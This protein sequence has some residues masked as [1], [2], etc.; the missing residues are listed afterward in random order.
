VIGGQ[1][2]K[3]MKRELI[4]GVDIIVGTPGK[5]SDLIKRGLLDLSQ[6]RFFVL[7]EAD[8]I[9]E[10]SGIPSIMQIFESIPSGGAGVH[11]LQVCFFSAT[12]HSP[13]VAELSSKICVNPTWVDLKGPDSVP[14]TVHH[15]VYRVDF[16]RDAARFASAATASITDEVHK[17]IGASAAKEEI[18]S[19]QVKEL[20]QQALIGILDAFHV[21]ILQFL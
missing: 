1:A 20:K 21:N 14:E 8:R 15:V 19:K 9:L 7:D 17:G 5:I 16:D 3:Q 13:Q 10:V 12:L 2:D 6:I 18:A 4:E 11:R